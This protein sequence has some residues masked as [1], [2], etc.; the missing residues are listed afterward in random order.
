[1]VP[2]DVTKAL[3]ADGPWTYAWAIRRTRELAAEPNSGI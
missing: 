3:G 1:M 2:A